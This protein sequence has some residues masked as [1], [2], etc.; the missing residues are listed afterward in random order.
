MSTTRA[1]YYIDTNARG[2]KVHKDILYVYLSDK[3][4]A[5]MWHCKLY[6]N[7]QHLRQ[8]PPSL[9]N[10]RRKMNETKILVTPVCCNKSDTKCNISEPMATLHVGP[11]AEICLTL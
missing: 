11:S 5:N 1:C 6:V 4:A 7:W 2:S 8:A 9:H 3:H 10:S